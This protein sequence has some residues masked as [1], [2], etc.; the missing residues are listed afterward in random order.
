MTPGT[1][2]G[3][4]EI[5]DAIGAGGMGEVY[6]ARDTRLDRIVAVKTSKEQ[7]GERFEREARAV[8][9][10]NHPNICTLHDI[11]P[12]YLVM[13]YIEGPTLAVRLASGP[14]PLGEALPIAR[15][16]AEALEAAHEK[17]IVHRDLKPANIKLT[18]DGKVKVLDFGLAKA[19]DTESNSR[20]QADSPTLT[21][22]S[23]RAG[24]ILGTAGYMS[25]EQARG[26]PAD[27]RADIWSY[28]VVLLEMLTGRHTFAGETVSDTLAAVLRAEL[29]WNSLPADTPA[30]I[31]RLLRRCL[32]RDRKKRLPDI[33]VARLEID[34]PEPAAPVAAAPVKRAG[35]PWI[36]AGAALLAGVGVLLYFLSRPEPPAAAYQVSI[37]PPEEAA[38]MPS[39]PQGGGFALSPDGQMLAFVGTQ[40]GST[41]IWLRRMDSLT[42]RPLAGTAH[43]YYPFW[44]PDGRYVGFFADSKLKKI[45]ISGG[46][47]QVICDVGMGRGAAWSQQGAIIFAGS[48]RML[49]RVP[50]AGGQPVPITALNKQPRETAHY[51]PSFLPDGIHFLFLARRAV[52]EQSIICVGSLK[53]GKVSENCSELVKANGNAMFV[54]SARGNSAG[55]L[56][57]ARANTLVAQRFDAGTLKLQGEASPLVDGVGFLSNI[58]R[59]DFSTGGNGELIYGRDIFQVS[60]LAWI[61]RDG[62]ESPIAAE[63]GAYQ[64]VRLSPD[65]SRV[66]AARQDR[67]ASNEDVWIIDTVR[68]ISTRFTFDSSTDFFPVWSPDGRQIVFSSNRSGLPTL[69]QKAATGDSAEEPISPPERRG[70][71]FPYDWSPDGR[72]VIYEEI[73][74]ETGQNLRVLSMT[75]KHQS[76]AFLETPFN[77]TQAQFSPDGMWV[78]YTSDESGRQEIYV[79]KF[80]GGGAKFQVS[81]NG[82]TQPRWRGDGKELYFLTLDGK[83]MAAAVKTAGGAFERE[84]PKMLFS[85]SW[86]TGS[87]LG[88]HVYD[89]TRDGQR[90]L[91]MQPVGDHGVEPLTLMVNWQAALR[92]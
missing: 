21:L 90:F 20:S 36:V 77:E 15:Q 14:I 44:S 59:A 12:N 87:F 5:L 89:V 16:I 29:D 46:P 26:V 71:Q 68:A 27:K 18:P 54:P 47:A 56:V 49:A 74:S 33:A 1:R 19:F 11:G 48:G 52:R 10:L 40:Q 37:V 23:T 9:A 58:T 79:R 31:R 7:F 92:K 61:A 55:W 85:G 82:G 3:P 41:Q 17:G 4:Y 28:G 73:A 42:A 53:T 24:M 65:G 76:T 6:K 2:L 91:F 62:K 81:G 78:A 57:F 45:D 80:V 84:T 64:M 13:E 35:L 83:L 63:P 38:F 25:P 60:R 39:Q 86:T 66:A 75:G 70:S 22:S 34:E 50:A 43:G 8:A 88:P 67:Q 32:E 69:F 30:S 72:Y 51:W